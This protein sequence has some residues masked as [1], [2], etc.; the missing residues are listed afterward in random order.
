M[1]RIWADAKTES[2]A[3]RLR[4][5][6]RAVA[7]FHGHDMAQFRATDGCGF[8]QARC[9]RCSADLWTSPTAPDETAIV[10]RAVTENCEARP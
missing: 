5:Q 7:K 6:A 1:K 8:S 9:R 3:R 2:K 4:A 10:G